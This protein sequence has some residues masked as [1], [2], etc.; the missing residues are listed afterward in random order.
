MREINGKQS[1][2][3]QTPR[4]ERA[5]WSDL[6]HRGKGTKQNKDQLFIMFILIKINFLSI[7]KSVVSLYNS[8]L[9]NCTK[10]N[11]QMYA[12]ENIYSEKK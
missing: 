1:P 7:H 9:L 3:V 6:Y 12:P 2:Y 8:V 10:I 4:D 11:I 5:T